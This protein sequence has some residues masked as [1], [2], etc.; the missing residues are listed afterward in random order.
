MQRYLSPVEYHRYRLCLAVLG[1][2]ALGALVLLFTASSSVGQAM[3]LVFTVLTGFC[4]TIVARSRI[5]VR[6]RR[7]RSQS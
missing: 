7:G 6:L 2:A 4:A 3:L 5:V 1:P